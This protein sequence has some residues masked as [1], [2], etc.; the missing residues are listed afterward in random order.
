MDLKKILYSRK[1]R[2]HFTFAKEDTG[3]LEISDIE[4][5]ITKEVPA[6]I[7][8]MKESHELLRGGEFKALAVGIYMH[9]AMTRFALPAGGTEEE[10]RD[11]I[12]EVTP[13]VK[14]EIEKRVQYFDE[15]KATETFENKTELMKFLERETKGAISAYARIK[16]PGVAWR[17]K[18]DHRVYPELRK[19]AAG[20]FTHIP[21]PRTDGITYA[22]TKWLPDARKMIDELSEKLKKIE[23]EA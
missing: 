11:F 19:E 16:L 13:E 8:K 9:R 18:L 14:E 10:I 17:D 20:M 3:W 5:F 6:E 1:Y 21:I 4:P 23:R 7:R 12:K 15:E 2:T 22:W